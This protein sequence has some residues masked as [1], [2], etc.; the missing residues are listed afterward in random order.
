MV[1]PIPDNDTIARLYPNSLRLKLVQT[2]SRHGERSPVYPGGVPMKKCHLTPFLHAVYY[3]MEMRNLSPPPLYNQPH[4]ESLPS[5]SN[6]VFEGN[7]KP[8]SSLS[9]KALQAVTDDGTCFNGQLTDKGKNTMETMGACLR[10][11]YIDKL[12]FLNPTLDSHNKDIY[13]RSTDIARTL[14]SLQYLVNGLYPAHQRDTGGSKDMDLRVH[15]RSDETLYPVRECKYLDALSK[16]LRK[17]LLQ[18]GNGDIDKAF[19]RHANFD[20]GFPKKGDLEFNHL[21]SL[22]DNFICLQAHGEPLPAGVTNQDVLELEQMVVKYWWGVF[23][24][25]ELARM[26]IGRFVKDLKDRME[27]SIANPETSVKLAVYSAHDSTVGPL[28]NAFGVFDGQFPP[29]ASMV[30]F[31]LF[32]DLGKHSSTNSAVSQAHEKDKEHYVRMLYEG[33][34][35]HVP[36]CQHQGNHHPNDTTLCTW[37]AFKDA[38]DRAIPDNW[39]KMCSSHAESSGS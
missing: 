26:A 39:D 28:T 25:A 14:E 22:Y 13:L 36:A 12:K 32:E 23:K 35:T 17:D 27:D 9:L 37:K 30:A 21:N 34:P 18:Q 29:F 2:V 20:S 3:A 8:N 31:E 24:N 4:H 19:A 15:V 1:F 7:I 5:L 10:K 38:M 11:L 6:I 16:M 33:K